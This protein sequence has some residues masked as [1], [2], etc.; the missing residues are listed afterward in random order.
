MVNSLEAK[1]KEL[2]ALVLAGKALEAFD[3]FYADDVVMQENDQAPTI[4]KKA[5]YERE[6]AFFSAITDFRGAQV[7]SVGCS[8]DK[9]YVEWSFDYTHKE[10]GVRKYHQVA[11]Q[12]WKNGRIVKEQFY[13]G[14]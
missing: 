8:A 9:T 12:T 7:L 1:I 5:N 10:W 14:G 13:Y 2:N 3:S 11:V 4:G 6:V